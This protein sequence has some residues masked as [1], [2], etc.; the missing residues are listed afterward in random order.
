MCD[1]RSTKKLEIGKN[2]IAIIHFITNSNKIEKP[3]YT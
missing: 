3:S 1:Y 2:N